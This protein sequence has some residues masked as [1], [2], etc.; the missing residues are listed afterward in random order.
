MTL[1]ELYEKLDWSAVDA[2]HVQ[3]EADHDEAIRLDPGALR[4]HRLERLYH[5]ID[6][7]ERN[8]DMRHWWTLPFSIRQ[9][10]ADYYQSTGLIDAQ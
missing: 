5:G 10:V 1:R 8:G 7:L 9:Q 2:T 4:Q 6:A 3:W